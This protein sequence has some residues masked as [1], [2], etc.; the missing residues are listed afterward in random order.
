MLV[1]AA[2]VGYLF[3]TPSGAVRLAVLVSGHP[4]KALTV[5]VLGQKKSEQSPGRQSFLLSPA[6]YEP[7]T[8]IQ[9][10]NWVAVRHGIFYLGSHYGY[11]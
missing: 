5:R 10:K 2:L 4:V 6:P 9:L 1:A 3:L 11:G 8:D 7:V